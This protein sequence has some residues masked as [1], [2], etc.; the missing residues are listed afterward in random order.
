MVR[1]HP[2]APVF[3]MF[4][5][6]LACRSLQVH[7]PLCGTEQEQTSTVSTKSTQP[8][9]PAFTA[10]VR[11]RRFTIVIPRDDALNLTALNRRLRG[12]PVPLGG[13]PTHNQL[14]SWGD[15]TTQPVGVR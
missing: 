12:L 15:T 4:L 13:P 14:C 6:L 3:P 10:G 8:V 5:G 2:A 11:V 1:F 7:A 9:R